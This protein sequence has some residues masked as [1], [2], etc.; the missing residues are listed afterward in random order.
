MKKIRKLRIVLLAIL[1]LFQFEPMK[2]EAS[3]AATFYV[4]TAAV[5]EDNTIEVCV[6]LDE[7][8]DIGGIDLELVYDTEKVS[9]VSSS[10]GPSLQSSLSDIYHNEENGEIHYVIIYSN[11]KSAHGILLRATFQLKEGKSYQPQLLINDLLDNS[12][13][14]NEIPYTITYQQADGTWLDTQDMSGQAADETVIEE[15]LDKYGAP[16]D[17]D[18]TGS[19]ETVSIDSD[20]NISGTIAD[21]EELIKS[22]HSDGMEEIKNVA[23]DGLDIVSLMICFVVLFVIGMGVA[24]FVK[25]QRKRG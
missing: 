2:F 19:Q 20:N 16:E 12:I 7:V 5:L 11:A 10:L 15:T 9:F 21:T 17:L 3:S 8:D 23:N 13:E 18:D 6:Y 24:L 4:Q 14:I 25:R 1:F 22:E